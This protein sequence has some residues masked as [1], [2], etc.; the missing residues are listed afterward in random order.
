MSRRSRNSFVN[1]DDDW[2]KISDLTERRRVQNRVAQRN[3][4]KKLKKRLEDLERRA[5]SSSASPPQVHTELH[6]QPDCSN[7]TQKY[8][9]S[10]ENVVQQ[11]SPRLLPSQYTPP[12]QSDDKII[13]SQGFDRDG[14]RTPPLFAYH[15][16]PGL[17]D[18]VYPPF[19]HSQP[20]LAISSNNRSE[21]YKHYKAPVTDILSSMIHFKD[22]IKREID[23]TVSLKNTTYQSLPVIDPHTLS[24]LNSYEQSTNCSEVRYQYPKTP[25]PMPPTPK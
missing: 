24:P 25:L 3:Y 1:K 4:R 20:Y 9:R 15:T 16:Y 22:P 8:R 7:E 19:P 18:V 5:G 13:F 21:L 6:Q 23:E 2:T 12:M 17:E 11:V 10:P 14:S